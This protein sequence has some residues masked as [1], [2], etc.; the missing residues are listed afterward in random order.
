MLYFYIFVIKIGTFLSLKLPKKHS[1]NIKID[2]VFCNRY[3]LKQ[4]Q[5]DYYLYENQGSDG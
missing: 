5:D 3:S 1:K 2:C 4:T